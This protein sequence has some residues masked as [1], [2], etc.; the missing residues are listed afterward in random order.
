MDC[1]KCGAGLPDGAETCPE[2]GEAL[3]A[4][5][6][7]PAK[8]T[9]RK[10][11]AVEPDVTEIVEPTPVDEP[12][13]DG[14]KRPLI[15]GIVI[16]LVVVALGVGVVFAFSGGGGMGSTP[17]VAVTRMLTAYAAYDAAG[18]LAVSTHDQL[19]AA[20]EKEFATQAA[21]AKKTANGKPGVKDIKVVKVTY[22]T[23]D[24]AKA[25]SATVDV[26]ANWLVDP[27]TGEYAART[28]KLPVIKDAKTGVWLVQ[29]F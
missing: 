19:D 8:K 15:I 1:E 28:E 9:R 22:G 27:A 10:A 4:P 2:C 26:S 6:E 23:P 11:K 24:K 25:T 3:V 21:D 5:A 18:I 12:S 13:A 29:L 7:A 20:G 16:A 14:S 17:D